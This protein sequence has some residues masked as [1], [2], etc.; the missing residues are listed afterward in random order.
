MEATVS[1][2]EKPAVPNAAEKLFKN[3]SLHKNNSR[4]AVSAQQCNFAGICVLCPA[5]LASPCT[6]GNKPNDSK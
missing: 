3:L 4:E 5:H 2:E 6:P 1:D